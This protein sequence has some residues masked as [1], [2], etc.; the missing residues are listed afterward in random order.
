MNYFK[1]GTEKSKNMKINFDKIYDRYKNIAIDMG[2][3][4]E[5]IFLKEKSNVLIYIECNQLSPYKQ[6]KNIRSFTS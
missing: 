1:L 5:I 4:G 3:D 2:Y 6:I